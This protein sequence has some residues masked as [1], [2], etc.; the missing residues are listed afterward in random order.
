[1]PII[2]SSFLLGMVFTLCRVRKNQKVSV[3]NYRTFIFN[4]GYFRVSY[5]DGILR[6]KRVIS[7]LMPINWQWTDRKSKTFIRN[8][9]NQKKNAKYWEFQDFSGRDNREIKLTR[10][11]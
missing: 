2:P 11:K 3:P 5:L 6:T 1:M 8:L 4:T 7:H 10:R 9:Q